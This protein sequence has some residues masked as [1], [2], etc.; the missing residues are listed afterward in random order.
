MIGRLS[1]PLLL[2]PCWAHHTDAA[3]A[4]CRP[5]GWPV[6]S[7]QDAPPELAVRQPL[8][9]PLCPWKVREWEGLRSS[10]SNL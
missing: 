6:P 2:K 10:S 3:L 5:A 4:L 1:L 7:H 8:L 9:P